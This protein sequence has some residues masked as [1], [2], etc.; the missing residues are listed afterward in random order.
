MS[1]RLYVHTLLYYLTQLPN[2]FCKN[3]ATLLQSFHH[4]ICHSS[5]KEKKKRK[6][7]DKLRKNKNKKREKKRQ[8]NWKK[9][10]I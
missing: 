1:P 4:F 7:K 10:K 5:L 6:K 3:S 9:D 8:I 2:L